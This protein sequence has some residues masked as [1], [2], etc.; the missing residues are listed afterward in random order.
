[1]GSKKKKRGRGRSGPHT[2]QEAI[3]A[4]IAFVEFSFDCRRCDTLRLCVYSDNTLVEV[5]PSNELFITLGAKWLAERHVDL[6]FGTTPCV[7]LPPPEAC[8]VPYCGFTNTS[9]LLQQPLA[10]DI[11]MEDVEASGYFFCLEDRALLC[12]KCDISIHSMNSFVSAHQR[13]LLTGVRVEHEPSEPILP[14]ASE[15]SSPIPQ[16]RSL[17]KISLSLPLSG[18]KNEVFSQVSMNGS[19]PASRTAFFDGAMNTSMFDLPIDDLFGM[20]FNQSY[21]FTG[22]ESPKADSGKLGSSE[23]SQ[24]YCPADAEQD[25]ECESHVPDI[26]Q[27]AV[28]EIPSP[29][30]ASGLN[31]PRNFHHSAERS[32]FVPDVCASSFQDPPRHHQSPSAVKCRKQC[33]IFLCVIT[34]STTMSGVR[35]PTLGIRLLTFDC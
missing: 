18:D 28:P 23:A 30:T 1:M 14:F 21:G 32:V 10:Q 5:Y 8:I 27:W 25:L 13:F 24:F 35:R 3:V 33:S 12:R 31:W 17:S 22:H 2:S 34:I 9:E 11:S 16:A 29:P 7:L 4:N 19:L 15:Q 26:T 20:D 6:R